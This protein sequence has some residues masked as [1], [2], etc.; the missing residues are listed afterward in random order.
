MK[1]S[2]W[3]YPVVGG[4][5]GLD[6]MLFD[7]CE[8]VGVSVEEAK[9]KGRN[10]LNVKA[11]HLFAILAKRHTRYSLSIIGEKILQPH[12]MILFYIKKDNKFQLKQAADELEEIY[13]YDK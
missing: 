4:R 1:V 6:K 7:V 2:Y 11:R 8:Y 9:S 12:D 13:K 5:Y 3:L 10:P